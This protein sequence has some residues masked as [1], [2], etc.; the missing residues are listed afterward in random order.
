[1]KFSAVVLSAALLAMPMTT[2]N[3]SAVELIANGDFAAGNF[4]GWT[5]FTTT[6]GTLGPSP[7]PNVVSFDTNGGGANNAAH[8]EVGQPTG[9]EFNVQRGGGLRQS[10][11]TTAAGILNFS[12]DIAAM[13]V[14]G[15]LLEIPSRPA[16]RDLDRRMDGPT[17]AAIVLAAGFDLTA[18]ASIGSAIA[19]CVFAMI[20]T[21]H[22]RV[23]DETGASV[24]LL[25]LA[26]LS[27]VTVLATFALT[28]L[29]EEPAT[30][31]AL[32][33]ILAVSIAADATSKRARDRG[34]ARALA[35]EGHDGDGHG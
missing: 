9:S 1:M 16:P 7:L 15:L 34:R 26:I 20:A 14:G 17:V 24:W 3:A 29:V 31:A 6:N 32:L 10:F 4:S 11:A 12:A 33:V 19:L 22:L 28:T 27:T 35:L 2:T 8:F 21:A 5:L 13:G 30:A 25:V 23:R 18:I